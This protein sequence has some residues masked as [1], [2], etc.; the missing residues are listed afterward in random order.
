[1]GKN[2]TDTSDDPKPLTRIEGARLPVTD[3]E[4]I[5]QRAIKMFGVTKVHVFPSIDQVPPAWRDVVENWH[6]AKEPPKGAHVP[7]QGLL[8]G[9]PPGQAVWLQHARQILDGVFDGCDQSTRES[10][11][12]GLRGI[13]HPLCQKASARL[14]AG[15]NRIAKDNMK[16]KHETAA[17]ARQLAL[18]PETQPL[19]PKP[20][21]THQNQTSEDTTRKLKL[22]AQ[23]RSEPASHDLDIGLEQCGPG[24]K[25]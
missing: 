15:G 19:P 11:V 6:P 8:D 22:R 12:I 16:T 24:D 5:V 7:T 23:H 25:S 10:L 9:L 20:K 4:D 17:A 14:D 2:V 21:A 13:Q 1:M 3:E 18:W